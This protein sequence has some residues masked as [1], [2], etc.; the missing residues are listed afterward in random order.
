VRPGPL[1]VAAAAG[2]VAEYLLQAVF[3]ADF[4]VTY[5][6]R[7]AYLYPAAL[8]LWVL[9]ADTL[10]RPTPLSRG[11]VAMVRTVAV[12]VSALAIVGNANQF[13]GAAAGTRQLRIDQVAELALVAQLGQAP[14]VDREI[15]P[16]PELVPQLTTARYLAAVERWGTPRLD[17]A[18]A[19][20][21]AA[22]PG[23][24]DRVA[25]VLLGRAFRP[26]DAVTPA[27]LAIETP[28]G[29]LQLPG[30]CARVATNDT[31]TVSSI[32][33]RAIRLSSAPGDV[34]IGITPAAAE[35]LPPEMED[36]LVRGQPILLPGGGTVTWFVQLTAAGDRGTTVC[37]VS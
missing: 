21:A 16:D 28:A 8:F 12:A 7:S 36:R 18:G 17:A 31:V 26:V 22:T 2:L 35:H 25:L 14:D 6:A 27:A 3:R 9:V 15:S 24:L 20:A 33:G 19:V 10:R 11:R 23:R 1:G 13:S 32:G 34:R 37:A 4:G 29:A 5:S 30:G